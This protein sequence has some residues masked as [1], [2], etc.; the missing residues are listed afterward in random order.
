[1]KFEELNVEVNNITTPDGI[2]FVK[3]VVKLA[4]LPIYHEFYSRISVA[5][6]F[7]IGKN[8]KGDGYFEGVTMF[9]LYTICHALEELDIDLHCPPELKVTIKSDEVAV[10]NA[11]SEINKEWNAE[12]QQLKPKHQYEFKRSWN[13]KFFKRLVK[14]HP[15]LT[16]KLES[17][18]NELSTPAG[19]KVENE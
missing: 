7:Y 16:F 12:V 9:D 2:L 4:Q 13:R 18:L 19:L 10:L 1:M 8:G 15:F 3:T 6:P 14:D 17:V 5:D 11:A